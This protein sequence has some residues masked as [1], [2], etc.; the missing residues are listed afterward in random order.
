MGAD[1]IKW[2]RIEAGEYESE[3]ERFTILKTWNRIYGNHWQ[4]CDRNERDHYKG[5]YQ[6]YTL[7]DCKLKAEI[8]VDSEGKY[9][10]QR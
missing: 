9:G 8:I 4:L 5:L 1:M 2:K 10:E 3:D 6:E 7:L